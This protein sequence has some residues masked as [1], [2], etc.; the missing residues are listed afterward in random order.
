MYLYKE[1]GAI[2]GAMA[3]TMY[4]GKDYH[5]IDW[6]DFYFYEYKNK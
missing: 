1:D 3:I 2:V 6:T 5:A 4:Q